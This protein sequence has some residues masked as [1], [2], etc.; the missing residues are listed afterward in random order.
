MTTMLPPGD[1][2]IIDPCYILERFHFE[3]LIPPFHRRGL[4]QRADRSPDR[5]AVWLRPNRDG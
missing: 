5:G 1:Y 3:A 4:P 2:L